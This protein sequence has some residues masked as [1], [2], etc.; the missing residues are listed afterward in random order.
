MAAANFPASLAFTLQEEGGWSD[1]PDDP[2]GQTMMGITLRTFQ[3]FFHGGTAD[4][5]RAIT[6][7]QAGTIYRRNYWGLMGCDNLPAGVDL[8]AF[9]FG[10]NAGPSRSIT[11]LQV[12]AGTGRDGIDGALTEAAVAKMSPTLVIAKLSRLQRAHYQ[13]LPQFDEFGSGWL[14]RTD[15]RVKLALSLVQP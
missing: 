12:V 1:D 8:M 15:R 7:D 9:D 5:L 2:G 11:Y 14:A 3:A 13:A 6:S 4:Q 10:V